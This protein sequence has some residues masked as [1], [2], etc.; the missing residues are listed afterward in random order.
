MKLLSAGLEIIFP[1]KF[2]IKISPEVIRFDDIN[3][4]SIYK[5]LKKLYLK[6]Y[7]KSTTKNRLS[8]KVKEIGNQILLA[9]FQ[10]DASTMAVTP[11][12]IR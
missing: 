1:D 8:T 2:V 9:I 11:F 12:I 7:S 6:P 5:Q 4:G 10:T 3:D